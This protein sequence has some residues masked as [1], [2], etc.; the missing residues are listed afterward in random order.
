MLFTVKVLMWLVAG[1]KVAKTNQVQSLCTLKCAITY[2]LLLFFLKKTPTSLTKFH[3][4]LSLI[5]LS[6][7]CLSLS[8][9]FFGH[10]LSK[11]FTVLNRRC[12]PQ[13]VSLCSHSTF[14]FSSTS[15]HGLS[16]IRHLWKRLHSLSQY[17]SC[18]FEPFFSACSVYRMK[19]SRT[20]CFC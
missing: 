16:F 13:F 3:L 6:S 2:H 4:S 17:D 12:C 18:V 11:Y 10:L 19:T 9:T 5:S 8:V 14:W 7:H 15:K 20:V 1:E